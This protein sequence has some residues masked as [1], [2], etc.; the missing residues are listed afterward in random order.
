MGNLLDLSPPLLFYST[1]PPSKAST[2]VARSLLSC[3]VHP[4]QISILFILD[5]WPFAHSRVN[6]TPLRSGVNKKS[7]H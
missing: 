2:F 3:L 4:R 5:Q 6:N 1:S 7:P